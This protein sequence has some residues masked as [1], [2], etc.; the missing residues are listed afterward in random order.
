MIP[1]QVNHREA[2]GFWLN[3]LNLKGEMAEIGCARGS[4]A[5]TVLSQW[6][7]KK[8]HMIDP[9]KTQDA[10][11]YRERQPDTEEYE[12]QYQDCLALAKDDERVNVIR[13]FSLGAS[14]S[15]KKGQLCCAYID[16]NHS[17][18]HVMADM[19][20]WWPKVKVG[21]IMGG[22]DF[23]TKID[24]GWWA[25]VDTAVKRW[26]GEHNQVFYVCPC[27]SWFIHKTAP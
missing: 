5:R 13:D 25:E 22:H 6:K 15:F 4:F 16:A 8:Y 24:E 14:A 18:A 7:G 10:D 27:T 21:G 12:D 23:R 17:Y 3:I 1:Q 9:W 11:V 20:A 2:L 19:D 26:A